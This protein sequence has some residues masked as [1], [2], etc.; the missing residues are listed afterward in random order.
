MPSMAQD[1]HNEF[2][3]SFEVSKKNHHGN[4]GS[5]Y[6]ILRAMK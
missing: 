3:M 2:L 5:A 1:E 4:P 6:W